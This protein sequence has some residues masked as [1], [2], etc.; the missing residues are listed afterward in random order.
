MHCTAVAEIN[1]DTSSSQEY[2]ESACYHKMVTLYGDKYA[3]Q[4]NV[5]IS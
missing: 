3:N 4:L 5:T 1:D 2:Q